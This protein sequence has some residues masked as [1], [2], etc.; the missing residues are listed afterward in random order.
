MRELDSRRQARTILQPDEVAG[1]LSPAR[2]LTTTLGG[3]VRPITPADL[4]EFKKTVAALGD[5]ARQ[6]LTAKEALGLS[7]AIDIDRAKAEIRYSLPSRLVVGKVHL[8]TDSGPRSKVSRHHVNIE[9]VQY[10]AALARPGTSTQA[11]QWLLK[12][13][14]LRFECDCEHFRYFLRFVATAGGWVSGRAEH[15]FPKLTNPTLDGACCKHLTRVM[16][17]L[18]YSVGLRQRVAQM[19]E[20]DRAR[21][22][23]PGKAKP[24]VFIVAQRDAEAMLPKRARRIVVQPHQRGAELPPP[25]SRA[26]IAKALQAYTGRNDAASAAIARAL[27]ALLNQPGPRGAHQ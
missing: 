25:A 11:A 5:K 4:R 17:D 21:I 20:A 19:I 7:R 23:K 3:Q 1:R 18:Q 13:G 9:F 27:Q 12:D 10:A 15:G 8:V 16:T 2:L 6:G 26:D 22:D 14:A 24:K